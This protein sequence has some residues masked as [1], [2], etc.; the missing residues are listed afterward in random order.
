MS[1]AEHLRELRNRILYSLIGIL[2]GSIIGWF[3][4]QPMADVMVAPLELLRDEGKVAQPNFGTVGMAFE[5]QLKMAI[6]IGLFISS[7]WWLL[8]GWLFI[9]PALKRREKIIALSFTF[10]AAT[11][12]I[13]GGLFGWMILPKAVVIL[14]DFAPSFGVHIFDAASYYRFFMQIIFAFGAAF[15]LPVVLVALNFAH[16]MKGKTLLKAWRWAVVGCAIFA[17]IVNPLPDAWSM[18]AIT[19]PMIALYF[20]ATGIAL[21]NDRLRKKKRAKEMADILG[22]EESADWINETS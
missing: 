20:I 7:P 19:L 13:G 15:L 21:F 4:Y 2:I 1:L 3:L 12:F 18:L 17:A 22:E 5:L 11:L 6:F 10:A 9:A 14:T 16:I 8:Q